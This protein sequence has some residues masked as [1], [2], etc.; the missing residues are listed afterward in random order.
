[1]IKIQDGF[2]SYSG[3]TSVKSYGVCVDYIDPV[4]AFK[5][6]N[7]MVIL[8]TI[9]GVITVIGA[10]LTT[11]ISFPRGALIGMSA[12]SFTIAL[13]A[14]IACGVGFAGEVCT[15]YPQSKCL[16][17]GMWYVLMIGFLFWISAGTSFL[18]MKKY[19]RHD[20]GAM[21]GSKSQPQ[22]LQT[23]EPSIPVMPQPTEGSAST[24]VETVVNPD[25]TKTKTTTVT[26]IKDGQT[27]VEKTTETIED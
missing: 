20:L 5:A 4:S 16:P 9:F 26:T 14:V 1:M 2:Y 3:F 8:S 27:I 24:L 7:A 6:G 15:M 18:F 12:A 22:Q 11:F 10:I 25:G 23:D 17:G 21:H 13:L 19:E